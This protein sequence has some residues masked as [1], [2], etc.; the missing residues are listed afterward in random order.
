MLRR[1]YEVQKSSQNGR[2]TAV[3]LDKRI[4][5]RDSSSLDQPRENGQTY[6]PRTVSLDD[7]MLGS[8]VCTE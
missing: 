3:S 5:R 7:E 8:E 1:A 4:E 6:S 2:L